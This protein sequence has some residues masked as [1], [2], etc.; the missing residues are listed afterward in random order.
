M[1]L[2][3]AAALPGVDSAGRRI[4][5][6]WQREIQPWS[7][8]LHSLLLTTTI[9]AKTQLCATLMEVGHSGLRDS[10]RRIRAMIGDFCAAGHGASL[11]LSTILKPIPRSTK[12]S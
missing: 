11:E 3:R 6:P 5:K 9:A 10:I 4:R 12:P 8:A 1:I 7:T 2:W